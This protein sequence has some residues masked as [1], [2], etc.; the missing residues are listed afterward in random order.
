MDPADAAGVQAGKRLVANPMVSVGD[1]EES[2]EAAFT[3]LNTRNLDGIL[4]PFRTMGCTWKTAPKAHIAY[5]LDPK[6]FV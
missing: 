4:A 2:L 1:I 5:H 3:R 6:L